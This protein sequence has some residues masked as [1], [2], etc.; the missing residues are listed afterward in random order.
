MYMTLAEA[1]LRF[2]ELLDQYA[3]GLISKSE[4]YMKMLDIFNVLDP[5][6]LI[7]IIEII[8]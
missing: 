1:K 3:E 5:N 4:L 2:R 8:G 7:Q 6:A